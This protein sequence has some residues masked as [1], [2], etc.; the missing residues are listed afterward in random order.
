MYT[1]VFLARKKIKTSNTGMKILDHKKYVSKNGL[2]SKTFLGNTTMC[3]E[4]PSWCSSY[5]VWALR[6]KLPS[7]P[8]GVQRPKTSYE[9]QSV[10]SVSHKGGF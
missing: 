4:A 5:K 8:H 7:Y 9:F 1:R 2:F 10:R 6:A 3:K